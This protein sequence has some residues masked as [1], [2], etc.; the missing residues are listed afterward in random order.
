MYH[1]AHRVQDMSVYACVC[2]RMYICTVYVLYFTKAIF[3]LV[4]VNM[5]LTLQINLDNKI[6]RHVKIQHYYIQLLNIKH[7]YI[8]VHT[9]L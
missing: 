7:I 1:V 9:K 3:E 5:F 2:M 8:H 4:K 6:R